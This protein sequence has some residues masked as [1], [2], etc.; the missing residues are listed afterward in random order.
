MNNK[1]PNMTF[2]S[3]SSFEKY[4][5]KQENNCRIACLFCVTERPEERTYQVIELLRCK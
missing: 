2:S 4:I 5:T 1:S 3:E